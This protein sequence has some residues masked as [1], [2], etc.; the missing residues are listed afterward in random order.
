V[1]T[2]V[3]EADDWNDGLILHSAIFNRPLH[4]LDSETTAL[5]QR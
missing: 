5:S 2:A 3:R 4:G 1:I